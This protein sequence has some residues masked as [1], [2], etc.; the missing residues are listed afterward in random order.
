MRQDI[1]SGHSRFIDQAVGVGMDENFHARK[2][3]E[4]FGLD[5]VHHPVRLAHGHF[6]RDPD[7]K[8]D[9]I[10]VASSARAQVVNP[11]QLGASASSLIMTTPTSIAVPVS[12]SGSSR[13][14]PL[15]ED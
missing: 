11:A 7:V 1:A 13:S 12:R 3:A 10:A 9:E 5:L 6:R 14:Y 8:L 2:L 4:Q 15:S